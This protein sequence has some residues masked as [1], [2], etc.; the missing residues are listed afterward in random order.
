MGNMLVVMQVIFAY[1][2]CKKWHS[3]EYNTLRRPS[4]TNNTSNQYVREGQE[5]HHSVATYALR[6]LCMLLSAS[7][8]C[9]GAMV[10]L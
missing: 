7:Y 4:F 1:L 5:P 3:T 9:A 6:L 8:E 2:A 10:V